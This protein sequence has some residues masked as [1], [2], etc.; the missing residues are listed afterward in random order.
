MIS[1]ETIIGSAQKINNQKTNFDKNSRKTDSSKT[2][3]VQISAKVNSRLNGIEVDLR[4]VQTELTSDQI[5]K[6]ALIELREES[7][8][9]NPSYSEV[10]KNYNSE[11]RNLISKYI[12]DVKS[13][14]GDKI[15]QG[16]SDVNKQISTNVSELKRIQIETENIFASD[17][18]QSDKAASVVKSVETYFIS[19]NINAMNKISSLNADVV[20]RLTR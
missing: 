4:K 9:K 17:M 20:M 11:T 1:I 7:G 14:T 13:L 5:I 12:G 8:S 16:L 15:E 19:G 3:T 2:D 6:N 10:L 18:A